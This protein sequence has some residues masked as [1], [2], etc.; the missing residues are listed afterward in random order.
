MQL[1]STSFMKS[2]LS[3]YSF[4]LFIHPSNND[5]QAHIYA[6]HYFAYWDMVGLLWLSPI[7]FSETFQV[8]AKEALTQLILQFPPCTLYLCKMLIFLVFLLPWVSETA[9]FPDPLASFPLRSCIPGTLRPYPWTL[10][11]CTLSAFD[12][13]CVLP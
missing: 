12:P 3:Y 10:P 1:S 6:R 5:H 4:Q 9:Y 13:H 2:Y 11:P 8:K 7:Y